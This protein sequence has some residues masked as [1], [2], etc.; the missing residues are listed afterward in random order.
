MTTLKYYFSLFTLLM[1]ISCEDKIAAPEI[2]ITTE[3]N[4]YQAGKP[5]KFNIQGNAD[6][7]SFYS[8]EPTND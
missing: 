5:V 4:T 1:M 7:I 2:Q 6:M 3:S 8:G